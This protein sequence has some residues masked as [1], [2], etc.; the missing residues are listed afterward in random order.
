M[1]CSQRKASAQPLPDA[2]VGHLQLGA[3]GP[4]A[5]AR[6]GAGGGAPVAG[7]SAVAAHGDVEHQLHRLVEGRPRRGH[8]GVALVHE[9]ADRPPRRRVGVVVL[10]EVGVRLHASGNAALLPGALLGH[11]VDEVPCRVELQLGVHVDGE[12]AGLPVQHEGVLLPGRVLRGT[13]DVLD[14]V[15]GPLQV[16]HRGARAVVR[17]GAALAAHRLGVAAVRLGRAVARHEVE[18]PDA[19][20]VH[21]LQ[22][23]DLPAARPVPVL[24]RAVGVPGQEPERRPDA[25]A[26]GHLRAEGEDAVLEGILAHDAPRLQPR[27]IGASS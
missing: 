27:A 13:V 18:G 15:E 22:D 21:R 14:L 23:V 7:R 5:R 8:A 4:A 9:A 6:G 11:D 20:R 17:L 16:L 25:V 26:L 19:L 10:L 12:H 2:D 3:D 24:A 1:G